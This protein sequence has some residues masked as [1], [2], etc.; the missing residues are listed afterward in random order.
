MERPAIYL[1]TIAA[2]SL[3]GATA[4]SLSGLSIMRGRELVVCIVELAEQIL[5]TSMILD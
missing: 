1:R 3:R 5:Q 2:G 4:G